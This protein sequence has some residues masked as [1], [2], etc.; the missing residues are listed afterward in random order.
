MSAWRGIL[1]IGGIATNLK[2]I[3]SLLLV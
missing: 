1:H 3:I 2:I